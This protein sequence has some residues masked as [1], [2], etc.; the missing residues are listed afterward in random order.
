MKKTIFQDFILRRPLVDQ[1]VPIL[2]LG[3]WHFVFHGQVPGT[4]AAQSAAYVGLS[5]VAG[6]VLAAATFVCTM[7]YQSSSTSVKTLRDKFTGELA[8]NWTSIFAFIF[9]AAIL[10]I[11]ATLLQDTHNALAFGL[12]LYSGAILFSRSF[13]TYLWLIVSFR[14][15]SS[16]EPPTR[17]AYETRL[18][19]RA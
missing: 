16:P 4:P 10:P 12:A 13:R 17:S 8:K 1:L 15:E 18:K 6:I 7:L 2:A 5:A 19:H 11:I 9:V 3:V 14:L